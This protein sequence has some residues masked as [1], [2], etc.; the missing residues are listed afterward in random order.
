M[1]KVSVITVCYNAGKTIK[2]TIESVLSQNYSDYE[3]VVVDGTSKDDTLKIVNSYSD[4][5]AQKGI[6]M[7]VVSE[8]DKGI[9]DAMNKGIDLATGD[10]IIFMNADDSFYY[11]DALKDVFSNDLT[12][13]GVVYGD[14]VRL[15]GQGAYP[16]KANPPETLPKQMPFMHQAVFARSELCKKYKFDL[17]YKLCA[18]YDFFFKIYASGSKFKQVD[19]TVCNYSIRGISGRALIDAQK[20]VI[21]IKKKHEKQFPITG[22]DRV[23]WAIDGMR[24]RIKMIVP[25][26]LLKK[27][28]QAKH[29]R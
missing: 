21:A 3:Y 18:D 17:S 14:C 9:Y 25:E 20:E 2:N 11:V 22:K 29:S 27:L 12:G 10:W 15:D 16:M 24:M 4:Q 26:K 8:Q 23:Q 19:I 5:F 28:R 7:T 1:K 13:Y 6:P